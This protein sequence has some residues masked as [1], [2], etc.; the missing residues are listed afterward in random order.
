MA[1]DVKFSEEEMK[2]LREIQENYVTV[3]NDFGQLSVTKIRLQQQ[4]DNVL[5]LE[6]DTI[7]KFKTTQNREKDFISSITKNYGE[8]QLDTESGVFTKT[9]K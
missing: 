5:K 4:L 6:E 3:Q 8:G 9:K 7:T 1:E 2:E